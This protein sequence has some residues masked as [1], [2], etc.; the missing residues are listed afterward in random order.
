MRADAT[1]RPEKHPR[2]LILSTGEDVPRGK[3]LRARLLISEVGPGDVDWDCLT[4]AQSYASSGLLMSGMSGFIQWLD[5]QYENF[6]KELKAKSER[7]R[8]GQ[9]EWPPQ[10]QSHRERQ[11]PSE[12]RR[13]Y[14]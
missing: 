14:S 13:D 12:N 6:R 1:L 7:M 5:P 4:K 10:S 3:S 9:K 11:K 2:C 8:K